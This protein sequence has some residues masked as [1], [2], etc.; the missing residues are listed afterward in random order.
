MSTLCA[1]CHAEL[2]PR[3]VRLSYLDVAFTVELPACPVCGQVFISEEI[4][5]GRMRELEETLESK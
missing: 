1:Q 3:D 2:Q 4:A 5:H